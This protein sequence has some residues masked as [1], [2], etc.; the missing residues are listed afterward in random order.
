MM[1]FTRQLYQDMQPKSG[2]ERW[3]DREWSRRAKIYEQYEAIIHPLL[4]PSAVRFSASH[5]TMQR[6]RL[7]HKV[8]AGLLWFWILG[9]VEADV[10]D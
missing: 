3:A 8:R 5:F 6:L 2:R 4:P 1:F 9:D 7:F 10:C